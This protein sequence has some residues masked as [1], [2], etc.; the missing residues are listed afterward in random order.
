VTVARS[1]VGNYITGLEMAGC[2]ISVCGL[3]PTLAELRDAP[4]KTPGAAP[5]R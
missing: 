5:G 2:S 1:L 3:T 4:V